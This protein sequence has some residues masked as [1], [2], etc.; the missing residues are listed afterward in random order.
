[1][2][3]V[4]RIGKGRK[5][6]VMPRQACRTMPGGEEVDSIVEVIQALIPLGLAAVEEAL[7]QE[8]RRLAGERYQRTGRPPGHVRWGSQPGSVY[9]L[10]QKVPLQVPRVRDRRRHCEV[11]R[12]K[13]TC[14]CRSPGTATAGSCVGSC[15]AR[16]RGA[17]GSVPRRCPKPLG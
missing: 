17:T 13:P 9:L 4:V 7:G 11:S 15:W 5:V 16:A 12:W 3:K 14:G 1:M 2:K 6:Q 10:D 8:L